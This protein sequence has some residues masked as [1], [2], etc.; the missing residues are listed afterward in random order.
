MTSI[1]YDR[2]FNNFLGNVADYEFATFSPSEA[3]EEM[4]EWLHKAL[5][6]PY[7]RR[8]FS[9]LSL[10]DMV[11]MLSF[12]MAHSVDDDTDIEFVITVLAKQMVYEWVSP[13]VNSTTNIM[14]AFMGKEQKFY[15]QA[16]HLSEL[17]GIK[18][19]ALSEVRRLIRDRGYIWNSYLEGS[20]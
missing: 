14:Q 12:E 8:L 7:V 11:Q 13:M 10:D 3:N 6:R 20:S 5:A 15:A 19:D 2:I 17:R 4:T 1:Q 18:E 9:S 16:N